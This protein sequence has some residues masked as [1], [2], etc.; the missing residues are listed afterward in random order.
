[1]YYIYIA[2]LF[3]V[4]AAGAEWDPYFSDMK[5]SKPEIKEQ[6]YI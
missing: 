1:M 2:K 3:G 5:C 4:P 6:N